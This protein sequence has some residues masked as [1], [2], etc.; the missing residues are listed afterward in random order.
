MHT[1]PHIRTYTQSLRQQAGEVADVIV[2]LIAV[3]EGARKRLRE[4]P[5]DATLLLVLLQEDAR[6]G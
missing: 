5:D 2:L 1:H 4:S 3:D 6:H